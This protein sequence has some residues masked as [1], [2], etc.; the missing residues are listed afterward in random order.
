MNEKKKAEFLKGMFSGS[1]FHDSVVVG[2]AETGSV[3]C[4]N[5]EKEK[6]AED[7]MK[8]GKAAIMEYVGRLKP[9]VV[10]DFI[11]K[12]DEVWLR[13]LDLDEVKSVVYDRGRQ[14]NTTFNRNFVANIIHLMS[15]NGMYLLGTTDVTMA[16]HLEPQKGKDHPVRGCLGLSP[17]N[18]VKKAIEKVFQEYLRESS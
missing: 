3:V 4:Y 14:Q 10:S 13:V 17:E 18:K 6:A 8:Q 7:N 9:L 11:E 1:T 15:D 5:R 16:K 2:I 12:Y